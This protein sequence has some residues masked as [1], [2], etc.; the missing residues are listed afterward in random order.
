MGVS[1]KFISG[2][3]KIFNNSINYFV[4]LSA[5]KVVRVEFT[6]NVGSVLIQWIIARRKLQLAI[7]QTSLWKIR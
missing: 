7:D 5:F 2:A 4:V 1:L 6:F 3:N